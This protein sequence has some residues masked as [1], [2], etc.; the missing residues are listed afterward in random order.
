MNNNHKKVDPFLF[1]SEDIESHEVFENVRDGMVIMTKDP[2]TREKFLTEQDIPSIFLRGAIAGATSQ[3]KSEDPN[4]TIMRDSA[5]PT[6]V[7]LTEDEIKEIQNASSRRY[8]T[9]TQYQGVIDSYKVFIVGKGFQVSAVDEMQEVKDYLAEFIKLNKMTSR[10]RDLIHEVLVSGEV[11][12]RKFTQSQDKVA[13]VPA[14]RTLKYFEISKIVYDEKDPELILEFWRPYKPAEGQVEI[15]KI[16][17]VEMDYIKFGNQKRGLPP[18]MAS[19]MQC[20]YYDDWL[21]NRIVFNRLKTAYVLEEIVEG[22]PAQVTSLDDQHP[23][24]IKTGQRGKVIKRVPKPG[25]KLTHNKAIEY[26]WLKPEVG[27][28]DA[29]EDGR[30]IRMAICAGAKCPEFILGDASNSNFASTIVSQNPFVR[31]IEWFQDFF[32]D[33]LAALHEWAIGYGIDSGFLPTLSTET[34]M[35]EK[36]NDMSW[37]K[38]IPKAI[39]LKI[40]KLI[41]KEQVKREKGSILKEEDPAT[42]DFMTKQV[43]PASREVD[44][45]WPNLIAQDLLRDT[46]A[47]QIHQAMGIV[48]NETLSQ[49]LGYDWQEEKRKIQQ[50]QDEAGD[51][52]NG[53]D[54]ETRDDEIDQGDEGEPPAGEQNR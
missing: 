27:A 48:S 45:N 50:E 12:I 2:L 15:E 49:K 20:A 7:V 36:R 5:A 31:N 19:I 1:D 11:F 8:L 33:P 34:L 32:T 51:Q 22:T 39:G 54:D 16:P 26:K 9:D 4:F 3:D 46:Q 43:V 18:F 6:G 38:R 17:G 25:S 44:T 40:A 13:R 42:G 28:E 24:A 52:N 14:V 29:K 10:D 30:A 23:N 41:E 21:F 37:W 47:R 53:P 35:R